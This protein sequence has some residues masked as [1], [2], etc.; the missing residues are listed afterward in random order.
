LIQ[1]S[2]RGYGFLDAD[3]DGVIDCAQDHDSDGIPN[4]TDPGF[5]RGQ[6]G[7]GMKAGAGNK[8]KVGKRNPVPS[9]LH[10]AIFCKRSPAKKCN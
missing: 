5:L 1:H 7:E 4:C 2:G 10:H 3:G 8:P 6:A 9:K